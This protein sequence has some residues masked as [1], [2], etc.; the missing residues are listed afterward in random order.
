MV[1]GPPPAF[2]FQDVTKLDL[3]PTAAVGL[4]QIEQVDAR[5]IRHGHDLLRRLLGHQGAEGH[6]GSCQ[7]NAPE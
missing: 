3:G 4:T 2:L 5:L 7:V 1:R 6:P